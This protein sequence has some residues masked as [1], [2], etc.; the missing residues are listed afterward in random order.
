VLGQ[1]L[2]DRRAHTVWISML[3]VV[4]EIWTWTV[5]ASSLC[6]VKLTIRP[7]PAL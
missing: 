4:H 1:K 6:S 3:F 2:G 7:V 5:Q